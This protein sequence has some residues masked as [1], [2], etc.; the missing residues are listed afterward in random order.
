MAHCI[1]DAKNSQL[2]HDLPI[3]VNDSVFLAF[4]ED[5]IFTKLHICEVSRK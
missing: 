3:S 4:R 1:Y 5:F 2:G